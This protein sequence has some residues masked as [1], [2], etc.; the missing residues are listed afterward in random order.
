M[1]KVSWKRWRA[2]GCIFVTPACL[3]SVPAP[4]IRRPPWWRNRDGN[5]T[6]TTYNRLQPRFCA[7]RVEGHLCNVQTRKSLTAVV[8]RSPVFSRSVDE[9]ILSAKSF[10]NPAKLAFDGQRRSERTTSCRNRRP[11]KPWGVRELQAGAFSCL[12][13]IWVAA[14]RAQRISLYHPAASRAPAEPGVRR[15]RLRAP[16]NKLGQ[17]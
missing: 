11:Q 3:I 9:V 17:L 10:G 13:K 12:R 6:R 2:S 14:E 4:S 5:A 16:P 1:R 15:P 8:A 7:N